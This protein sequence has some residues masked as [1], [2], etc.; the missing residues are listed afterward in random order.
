LVNFVR[1]YETVTCPGCGRQIS[2]YIPHF[3]DGT[4]L[5]TVKHN[6]IRLAKRG[7]GKP[8]GC[9]AS[10]RIIVRRNRAWEIE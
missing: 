3:G 8:A 4:G 5:R 2:A 10:Q 7:L 6:S 1:K 9:P